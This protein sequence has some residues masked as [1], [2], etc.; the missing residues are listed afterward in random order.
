MTS[1][2][3]SKE[4]RDDLNAVAAASGTSVERQL[5]KWV[6]DWRARQMAVAIV[7][8]DQCEDV[9]IATGATRSVGSVLDA[10]G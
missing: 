5:R 6:N 2:K 10:G 9:E 1:I 4:T 3:V 8:S 7:A